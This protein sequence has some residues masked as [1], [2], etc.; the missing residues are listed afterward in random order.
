[1]PVEV[2]ADPSMIAPTRH[3]IVVRPMRRRDIPG[4]VELRRHLWADDVATVESLAWSLAHER[5]EVQARRWVATDRGRVVGAAAASRASWS[6]ARAVAQC[7]VG[8]HAARRGRG[9]GGLLFA[10]VERHLARIGAARTLCGTERGDE[11]SARFMRDRG[12][13][14]TR[15]DQAW[16]LDPRT[17]SLAE[18]PTRRAAAEAAG[19]RLVPVREL[20]NRPRDVHRLNM[21]LE[22]DLPSDVPIAEP[23]E[24]W[25]T[26]AFE[27][28]LFAPDASFCVLAAGEPIALTWIFLDAAGSRARHGMTGTLPAYRHRGLAHLVKLASIGWLADHGVTALFTDNDSA[29]R[30]M[31]DLNEHLGFR[32]LTV[33]ETWLRE[34]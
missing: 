15:D 30:E 12:F 32:P 2:P 6:S 8:V 3:R 18:F 25:R 9:I 29:N 17:V 11:P 10:E 31:L 34:G 16:S 1:V 5:A 7:H 13:H 14:H 28:P 27:T 33:F 21:A 19:F 20:L 22:G 4:F 26:T 24:S 23:Y